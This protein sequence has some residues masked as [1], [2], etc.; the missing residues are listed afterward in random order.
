MTSPA[1]AAHRLWVSL[2]LGC[3]LGIYYGFL[4]PLRRT[5]LRDALFLCG[6]FPAWLWQ[7]FALCRGDLRL[8][9]LAG[10]LGGIWLWDRFPGRFLRAPFALFWKGM[11]SIWGLFLLP[12]KNFVKF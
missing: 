12:L 1:V 3:A 8:G 11:A 2:L 4:R 7:S 9:Y 5:A 10:L 6:L